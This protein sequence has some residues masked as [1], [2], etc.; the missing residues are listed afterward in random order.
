MYIL[1]SFIL[2]DSPYHPS[3]TPTPP[4]LAQLKIS[5]II[6]NVYKTQ[7]KGGKKMPNNPQHCIKSQHPKK[8][9]KGGLCI[10]F[11]GKYKDKMFSFFYRDR[12]YYS[13]MKVS[14]IMIGNF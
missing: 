1:S 3:S 12:D 7:E 13:G 9:S 2:I 11:G 14:K 4:P 5:E 10:V 8:L 6:L